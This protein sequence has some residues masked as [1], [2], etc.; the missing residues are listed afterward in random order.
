MDPELPK[1]LAAAADTAKSLSAKIED[2][3]KHLTALQSDL[4]VVHPMLTQVHQSVVS[5][6]P[7]Y[8]ATDEQAED[9]ELESPAQV[10]RENPEGRVPDA[11]FKSGF[12][13]E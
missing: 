4:D 2:V 3:L 6:E 5:G 10:E 12:R 13:P 9:V 11:R 8:D 7:V 1:K